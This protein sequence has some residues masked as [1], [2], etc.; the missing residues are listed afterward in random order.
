MSP[1]RGISE[2]GKKAKLLAG[3]I[4]QLFRC[5]NPSITEEFAAICLFD[6]VLGETTGVILLPLKTSGF[7]SGI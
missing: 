2:D 3:I 6:V 7:I 5:G 4:N 1:T